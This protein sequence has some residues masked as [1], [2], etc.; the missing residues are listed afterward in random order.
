MELH[1]RNTSLRHLPKRP[2]I[3]IEFH[4][5]SYTVPQGRKG[6]KLILRSVNGSF[7]AGQLTAIMGPSGA[8]KSTLLNILAG[9]KTLG[10]TGQILINGTTRNLKQFRKMSRYIMQEDLIQPMLTVEEAMMIA[11]NLKLGDTLS[12]S[13]KSSAID[14]ILSLLRLDKA[15]RTSTSRLSGGER[16][17]LSIALELLNNP[18]VLFLDEPTTGL[19]DL[20][21]SQCISLLKKIA[22]GGRTV[23]CS[24]HTPSAKIFSQFDNV[25]ILSDGQCVYQG[26]GPEVVSYLSKVGIECPKH[27]NPADFII[28]VCCNEYGNFQER[29]VSVID[30]GRNIY[31]T[32]GNVPQLQEVELSDKVDNRSSISSISI[33]EEVYA[34]LSSSDFNHESTWFSQFWILTT[35]LWVQMW[36]DKTYLVMRTVLYVILA[37]LI[38]SLYYGMGQDGSK[39]IFNFGFYYCCL[40]FFMYIP[41]MPMLLQFPREIQLVKREHFNKW[42]RLSAYFSA[43]SFSTVPVQLCLGIVYVSCVYLLTDQPL[44]LRRI[45]MF[46]FICIL[47]SVISESLGLLIAAQLKVVNAVFMGPVSSVPFMLLAVYGFGSG[48]DT[49]PSI[50]KFFMH[51]SYLRYSLEGLIHAMLKDREKLSCPE[52][53]EYCIYTDLNF[54]VKD[55]G[56]ENTI[57]WVDVLVLIFILILFRGGS[58]YLLRQRLTPNKT[59]RALQYIG[60]L[61]KSQFGIAR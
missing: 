59:F 41:M 11:A 26:Y 18:P 57:Y 8:G 7:Q 3:D 46:F 55:M 27:Y 24:I 44:E 35:R 34:D 43:L 30:N 20:S 61:V 52:T 10:A 42:Y 16:K 15:K 54:F 12:P 36:R 21:C 9:Y 47:T 58:Y 53:E 49:I 33:K 50:I 1:S 38:G 19:D 60:R 45:S 40:I 25:Y 13:D 37:L 14:E 32:Y 51:F 48:Y 6:S 31:K 28:E 56:M 23:I 22:E 2:P 29:M 39:T 5:V 4:D 17:R